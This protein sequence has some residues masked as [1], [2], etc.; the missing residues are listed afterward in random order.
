M[1]GRQLA[2]Q[3][4]GVESLT[5]LHDNL[6]LMLKSTIELHNVPGMEINYIQFLVYKIEITDLV[7]KST[8]ICLV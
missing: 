5:I 7:I 4:T 6:L 3:N 2:L 1:L 8:L